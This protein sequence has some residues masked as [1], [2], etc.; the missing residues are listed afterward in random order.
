MNAVVAPSDATSGSFHSRSVA[1]QQQRMLVRRQTGAQPFVWGGLLP[2]LGL[3]ALALYALLPFARNDI[4]ATV[5]RDVQAQLVANQLNWTKLTTS[6]QNVLLTG[7][8]PDAEAAAKAVEAARTTQCTSW[9]GLQRCVVTVFTKFTAPA[10]AALPEP[11]AAPQAVAAA[12]A[13]A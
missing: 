5:H 11:V 3:A 9:T 13:Q 1:T 8:P 6:G 7:T 10:A 4:Q 12:A 2:L